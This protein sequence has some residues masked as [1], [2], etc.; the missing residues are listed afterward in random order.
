VILPDANG[1]RR[2]SEWIDRGRKRGILLLVGFDEGM[3]NGA[4]GCTRANT[5]SM[6]IANDVEYYANRVSEDRLE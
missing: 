5:V 2:G 3:H 6:S 4:A 1:G